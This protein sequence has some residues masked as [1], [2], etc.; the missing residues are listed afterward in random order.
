MWVSSLLMTLTWTIDDFLVSLSY[1]VQSS[2]LS[3]Y[4]W[5]FIAYYCILLCVRGWDVV[6]SAY[7]ASMLCVRNVEAVS[8]EV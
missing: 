8:R 7:T 3:M 4:F 6:A 5:H 1:Q 2:I